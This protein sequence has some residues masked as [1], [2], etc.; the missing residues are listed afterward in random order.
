VKNYIWGGESEKTWVKVK[1]D[2]KFLLIYKGGLGVIVLKIQAKAL[3]AKLVVKGLSLEVEPCKVL[4]KR[5][6]MSTPR[7]KSLHFTL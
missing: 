3:L 5:K 6:V 7:K 1:W 4:L 2:K